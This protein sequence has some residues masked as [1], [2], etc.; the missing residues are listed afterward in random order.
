MGILSLLST[1]ENILFSQQIYSQKHICQPHPPTFMFS[2]PPFSCNKSE[3]LTLTED[4]E[5]SGK[6]ETMV[7]KAAQPSARG[8]ACGRKAHGVPRPVN[9]MLPMASRF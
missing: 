2:A 8:L 1:K 9:P 3:N 7:I 4:G 6:S 5:A